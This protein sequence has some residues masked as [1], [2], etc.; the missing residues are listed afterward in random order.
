MNETEWEILPQRKVVPHRILNYKKSAGSCVF[1]FFR[2]A[3]YLNMQIIYSYEH[4]TPSALKVNF[5]QN[6]IFID[7][8]MGIFTRNMCHQN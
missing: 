8:I 6:F 4:A 5:I 1:L 2:K 7:K 3:G